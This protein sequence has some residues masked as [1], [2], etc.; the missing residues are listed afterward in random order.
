MKACNSSLSFSF[1]FSSYVRVPFSSHFLIWNKLTLYM[2]DSPVTPVQRFF[3][4]ISSLYLS[5]LR[6]IKCA[7]SLDFKD[8]YLAIGANIFSRCTLFILFFALSC[9]RV[10]VFTMGF[11]NP[12]H[13]Q[14]YA[15]MKWKLWDSTTLL[16]SKWVCVCI[17]ITW[18]CSVMAS[19]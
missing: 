1:S 10:D 2:L 13:V 18:E 14:Y 12:F 6:Y 15:Q 19:A 7:P 9:V 16:N 4:V 3:F 5:L 11:R 17:C 8:L